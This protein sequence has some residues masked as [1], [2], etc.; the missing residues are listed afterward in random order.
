MALDSYTLLRNDRVGKLGGG[1]GIYIH[2]SLRFKILALSPS[3]FSNAPEFLILEICAP[4]CKFLF[5]TIYRRPKGILL[6]GFL[7]EFAKHLHH[8]SSVI[9]TGDLNCDLSS[10]NFEANYLR[11]VVFSHSLYLVP[12]GNT[13]HTAH[14]DSSLDVVILDSSDKL[15]SF[16]KSS[17]PFIAGHDL[18]EFE[19]KLPVTSSVSR[20]KSYRDFRNC[21]ANALDVELGI[22]I[23]N[24]LLG[25]NEDVDVM[26]EALCGAVVGALDLHAPMV[27][28]EF[29]K[30]PAGWFTP[31]F[32]ERIRVRNR[33]YTA[34]KRLGCPRRMAQF[35][36]MRREMKADIDK[37][38]NTFYKERLSKLSDV[39][40]V[41][42][43]LRLLGLIA[44]S[45]S[46]SSPL[47]HFS[48]GQLNAF[49][50]SITKA[51]P[52]CSLT[53]LQ[54]LLTS[55]Q[56]QVHSRFSFSPTSESQVRVIL[57][58]YVSK[59]RGRS[60]DGIQLSHL[61]NHLDTLVPHLTRLFNCSFR[62]C[63]FPDI[64]KTAYI[65]PLSKCDPPASESD[66]RPVANLAHLSKVFERVVAN[67][68]VAHLE[69]NGIFDPAQSGFRKFHSTQSALLR[70]LDDTRKAVDD[71]CVTLLVLFDFSKAF[72]S[73]NHRL[74]L[75]K[76]VRYG[77]SG[78]V[79]RWFHSYLS[80]RSQAVQDLAGNHSSFLLNH[81][82][83]PQ[84]SVLGPLLFLLFINDIGRVLL[85]A[86]HIVFA[87]DLQI[88]LHSPPNE[89]FAAIE[90]INIDAN[91][92]SNWAAD[93]GLK[94]NVSKTKAMILGSSPYLERLRSLD[95]PA[96]TVRD[97]PVPYVDVVRNL[98]V[99]LSADLSWNA[100]IAQV[101]KKVYATLHR[102]KYRSE[103]LSPEIKT[104]L[105]RALIFPH[106]DYCCLVYHDASDYLNV[107]LQRLVN[108]GIRFIFN[109]RRDVHITP[110]RL[111]LHWLSVMNRRLFFLGSCVFQI[112]DTASPVY[113]RELFVVPDPGLRRSSRLVT[114]GN[115]QPFHIPS[116]R[117]ACYRHSFLLSALYFW[118]SLPVLVRGASSLEVFKVRLFEH[119]LALEI[120]HAAPQAPRPRL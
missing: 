103:I 46:G 108:S 116:H 73:I 63:T 58:S 106:L 53:E 89:I 22:K 57:A 20:V 86:H 65:I 27:T 72:D 114:P 35:R 47:H 68:L 31:E 8:Y 38:K 30:P 61:S 15:Q 102:L 97:Q 11:D 93:N 13:H 62:D 105:V 50:T 10:E 44:P 107:K 24:S 59:S 43:E 33:L 75:V 28:R 88:Y 109:L 51:H 67:Q 23:T 66:T 69:Q 54:E 12:L 45:N 55:E 74:L 82:G 77:L 64:W 4:R 29:K 17:V 39:S 32:K 87:D 90:R 42:S 9:I 84:G 6:E 118:E 26:A 52:P 110:Y 34:A 91:A 76:L 104:L 80:G 101:S 56:S 83:V 100:H 111:Q 2:N 18:I 70:V 41:W 79:V 115:P 78:E 96:V 37:A 81:S 95:I 85:H 16:V 49:Y 21:D 48:S 98:G 120:A 71:R 112:L 60:P 14:S 92:V 5:S 99:H 117:T 40:S 7:S 1:V 19:Y 94:L 36:A 25:L 3:P 113:L 119:L